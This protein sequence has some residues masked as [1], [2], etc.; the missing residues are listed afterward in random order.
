MNKLYKILSVLSFTGVIALAILTLGKKEKYGYVDNVKLISGYNG[1]EAVKSQFQQKTIQWQ[2]N[3]DTLTMDIKKAR[4]EFTRDS[5]KMN[6]KQRNEARNKIAYMEQQY[7]NY[8][9]S[10]QKMM[11]EEDQK[12]TQQLLQQLNGLVAKYAEVHGYTFIWGATNMGN[13]VY[14]DKAKNLTDEIL[15]EINGK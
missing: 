15:K 10:V 3:L 11:K 5:L 1:M 9:S 14:A 4:M 8:R 6:Q 7:I 13:I 2:A 12:M